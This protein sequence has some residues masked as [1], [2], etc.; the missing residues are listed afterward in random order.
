VRWRY[1]NQKRAGE[2]AYRRRVEKLM[3]AWW[4]QFVAKAAELDALFKGEISWD[5]PSWMN[6][7]LTVVDS[8]LMWEFGP[9]SNRDGHRLII[10]PGSSRQLRPLVATLLARAPSLDGWEF[11]EYR[12][13]ERPEAAIHATTMSTGFEA[14]RM[15]VNVS[16]GNDHLIDLAFFSPDCTSPEDEDAL[17]AA[18]LITEA[19]LGE[20]R[21]DKWIGSIRVGRRHLNGRSM[22]M[23]EAETRL[24]QLGDLESA[25][26]AM[27][28]TILGE[29]APLPLYLHRGRFSVSALSEA[30]TADAPWS[31]FERKGILEEQPR[32]D[33]PDKSDLFIGTS[34]YD[35][36]W[37]AM[38]DSPNFQSCRFSA[39]DET[40]CYLKIDLEDALQPSHFQDRADIEEQLDVAL[41]EAECGITIGGGSGR[42][43]AYIDLAVTD[44]QAAM[45]V[46]RI[47]LMRGRI[48]HRAWLQFCDLELLHE[49]IGVYDDTPPPP[50]PETE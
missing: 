28:E 39:H 22:Y 16:R 43:Y 2:V 3:D 40:F 23:D 21:L 32:P 18:Y 4:T 37:T 14:Q 7:H 11:Y 24:M 50:V 49:W 26:D 17:H 13:A 35:K 10:T 47:V 41:A 12:P 20:E 48:G 8:R 1:Y 27:A 34:C 30:T 36:L 38:F 6:E 42:R 9:A 44:V 29:C 45:K 31:I 19:L 25:V 46:I 5:L 33:Y 15:E